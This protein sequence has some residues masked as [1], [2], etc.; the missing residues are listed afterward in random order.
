MLTPRCLLV[1]DGGNARTTARAASSPR[2][3]W[4]I[5]SRTTG[6]WATML[7]KRLVQATL[8]SAIGS[9]HLGNDVIVS[10][11]RL[12]GSGLYF[13]WHARV[14]VLV[15]VASLTF[16]VFELIPQSLQIFVWRVLLLAS[17]A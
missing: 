12:L 9:P 1:L 6:A 3:G 11:H 14:S 2:L 13:H 15:P 5:P 8:V 17:K 16:Q 10:K 4:S 7:F